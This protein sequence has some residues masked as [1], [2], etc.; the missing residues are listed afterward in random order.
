[1]ET[2][3]FWKILKLPD[4]A[5]WPFESYISQLHFG[6]SSATSDHRVQ[7]Y[8]QF[9]EIFQQISET[10][11]DG[12]FALVLFYKVLLFEWRKH[13]PFLQAMYY[14][15]Y[16]RWRWHWVLMAGSVPAFI[17]NYH[18]STRATFSKNVIISGH[19]YTGTDLSTEF[20]QTWR[21]DHSKATYLSFVLDNP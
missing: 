17:S 3:C 18:T 20:S 12:R 2:L 9:C 16:A 5:V 19:L 15:F 4:L 14:L 11:F 1:M 21:C 10:T 7:R 13:S 6:Q 8:D